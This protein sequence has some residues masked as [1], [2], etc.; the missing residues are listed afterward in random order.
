MRLKCPNCE[1]AGRKPCT[2]FHWLKQDGKQYL[3]CERVRLCGWRAEIE[4]KEPLS[5]E[6]PTK[7]KPGILSAMIEELRP[8][9]R[10]Q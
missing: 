2:R 9:R 3:R 1:A 6:P 7:K 10:S 8:K 5:T 4:L